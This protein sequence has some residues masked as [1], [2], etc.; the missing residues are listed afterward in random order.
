MNLFRLSKTK[1]I[2]LL[3]DLP[4]A[5]L[6]LCLLLHNSCRSMGF[7]EKA[8]PEHPN[9]E[10]VILVHGLGRTGSSMLPLAWHLKERGYKIYTYDYPSTRQGIK[11]HG[12]VFREK[13]GALT[14]REPEAECFHLVTHS[15]GGIIARI[16]IDV[17]PEEKKG[18]LVMLAPPNNGSESAVFYAK[19]PFLSYAMKPLEDLAPQSSVIK[20]LP[21]PDVETGVV[22]ARC[23]GKVSVDESRLEGAEGP[24]VVP[25]FHTFVMDRKETMNAVTRFLHEGK[26]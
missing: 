7:K 5:V 15:L 3:A 2:R 22:A 4:P 17:I 1:R 10:I 9:G 16:A 18:R 12:A 21:V 24:F 11:K 19:I 26:F 20:S 23:D 6:L 14:R 8:V 25:G 13:L